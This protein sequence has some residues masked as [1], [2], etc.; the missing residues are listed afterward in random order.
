MEKKKVTGWGHEPE[1]EGS[2]LRVK[3]GV[4]INGFEGAQNNKME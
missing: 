1:K 4:K 3:K 2:E